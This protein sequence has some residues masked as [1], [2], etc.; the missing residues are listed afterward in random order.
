MRA[1]VP[2]NMS[3]CFSLIENEYLKGPWVLGE[4]FSIC[5]AYL[6]TISGWLAG[7][8][9]DIAKFPKVHAHFKRMSERPTVKKVLSQHQA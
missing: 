5:D 6:F 2:Q 1:K 7:D 3:E 9:V 8:G 4:A